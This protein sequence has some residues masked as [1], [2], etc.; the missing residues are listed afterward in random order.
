MAHIGPYRVERG[1]RRNEGSHTYVS[2]YT[3]ERTGEGIK[4]RGDDLVFMNFLCD[5]L[6]DEEHG[7]RPATYVNGA[8]VPA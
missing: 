1:I 2:C 5:L 8:G 4:V 6:N 3:I 7:R